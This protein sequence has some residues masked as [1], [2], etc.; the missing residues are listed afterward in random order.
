MKPNLKRALIVTVC[1]LAIAGAGV[2]IWNQWRGPRVAQEALHLGVGQRLAEE[3]A[4]V[5][6]PSGRLVVVTLETGM[7]EALDLQVRAFHQRLERWPGLTIA[8][9]DE[10]GDKGGKHGPG[11]GLSARRFLR[12]REKEKDATVVVSFLG[13]PDPE[14]LPKRAEAQGPKLV[15]FS[16]SPRELA[17]L[18]EGGWLARAIVPRFTFPAPGPETP[19]TPEEWF[20][21]RF[22]VVVGAATP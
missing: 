12:L 2:S 5:V 21:N 7:S 19:G 3:V 8:R 9:T 4:A 13:A 17:P 16:R 11:D 14:D 18:I 6:G 22:Q 20:E 1:L 10:V 15:A